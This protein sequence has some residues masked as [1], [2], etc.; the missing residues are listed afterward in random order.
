MKITICVDRLT[1]GGAQ[2]VAALWIQGFLNEGHDVSV[3]LSNIRTPIT[4]PIPEKVPIFNVDFNIKNGYVRHLCK[5]LFLSKK[6]K[7]A[8]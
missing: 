4:Y 5:V 2:R 8:L 3:V 1:G 6:F 7:K